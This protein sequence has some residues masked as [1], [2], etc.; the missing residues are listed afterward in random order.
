MPFQ[1][2]D[3]GVEPL[4]PCFGF[5]GSLQPEKNG[6]AVLRV[7]CRKKGLGVW[8]RGKGRRQVIGDGD[9]SLRIVSGLPAPVLF[10]AL[11]FMQAGCFHVPAGDQRQRFRTID[12]GPGAPDRARREAL[13]VAGLIG[14]FFVPVYPA[15]AQCSVKRFGIGDRRDC[16]GFFGDA[17]PDAGTGRMVGLQPCGPGFLVP[18]KLCGQ[19]CGCFDGLFGRL[20]RRCCH[21]GSPNFS[22]LPCGSS[23]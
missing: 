10:C 3:E 20:A 17:Q 18:E 8:G 16:R 7:Q 1:H 15:I 12:S 23:T 13:Q 6:V 11:D 22:R 5:F 4:E 9:V 2:G 19:A 14:T 21:A